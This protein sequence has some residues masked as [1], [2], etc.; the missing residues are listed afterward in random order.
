LAV[1]T[2][3]IAVL[4]SMPAA[5]P[6]WQA[7]FGVD[8][9]ANA[10]QAESDQALDLLKKLK[11][12]SSPGTTLYLLGVDWPVCAFFGR[13]EYQN[14]IEP[15]SPR[16]ATRI[17]IDWQKSSAIRA[18]DILNS[19]LIAFVPVKEGEGRDGI[20]ANPDVPDFTTE[21]RLA[22]AWASTLSESDGVTV[23]SETNVRLLKVVNPAK[24]EE[25]MA[26][27]EAEHHWPATRPSNLRSKWSAEDVSLVK[28][29]LPPNSVDIK[30]HADGDEGV[31]YTVHAATVVSDLHG[32]QTK[33]WVEPGMPAP[34]QPWYLFT[35]L[36][37]AAGEIIE[38]NQVLLSG[39][40]NTPA[41]DSIRLYSTF[42]KNRPAAA[43]AI[44]FGI[45]RPVG[46]SSEQLQ[47]DRGK[48]DSSGHRVLIPLP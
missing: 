25:S 16:I 37:N 33:F 24:L 32:L 9:L 21:L 41:D 26:R 14:L 38:N 23:V 5:P 19:S 15:E 1:P 39:L 30:F 20:L 12:E 47:A 18:D 45:Y 8:L 27:L 6:K 22:R 2:L 7:F 43:T 29:Q 48:T 4:L 10:Y 28:Q 44:A 35:H 13:L 3:C 36:V 34:E 40:P 31:L 17:G 46:Q 11:A 42:F